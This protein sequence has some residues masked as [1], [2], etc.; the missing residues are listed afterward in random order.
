MCL[1]L[2]ETLFVK[3]VSTW[4]D[5]FHTLSAALARLRVEKR[6]FPLLE[7]IFGPCARYTRRV[8]GFVSMQ[9]VRK[10]LNQPNIVCEYLYRPLN[11]PTADVERERG[12]WAL[13]PQISQG[14]WD[15]GGQTPDLDSGDW[16]RVGSTV[17]GQVQIMYQVSPD[18]IRPH[19][20]LKKTFSLLSTR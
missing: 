13:A 6:G 9:V 14:P 16:A 8:A 5:A 18:T 3:F 12:L 15:L 7:L 2:L 17:S 20:M 4:I 19:P 11:L 10:S 1:R